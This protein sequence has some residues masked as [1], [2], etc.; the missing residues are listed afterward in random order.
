MIIKIILILILIIFLFYF[1]FTY[2]EKFSNKYFINTNII[3]LEYNSSIP[4]DIIIKNENSIYYDYGNDEINEKFIKIYNINQNNLI[5]IIEG[6]EWSKWNNINVNSKYLLYSNTIIK[7]FE[8]GL[9][10]NSLKLLNNP[11]FFILYSKLN[12]FKTCNNDNSILLLDIDIIIYRNNKPLARH[13]KIIAISNGFYVNF[14]FVKIIGVIKQTDIYPHLLSA[15]EFDNY[16][17]YIDNKK[18][19]YDLN[20]FIFDTN[21][22]LVNSAI[23]YNLYNKLLKDL[24]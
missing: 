24:R 2:L 8:K 17:E 1:L 15:N 11:N 19:I 14:L 10:N 9:N 21:D 7:E 22:R 12:R 4:Y 18:I 13:I 3:P 16:T 20:S 6:M 23:E 5:K